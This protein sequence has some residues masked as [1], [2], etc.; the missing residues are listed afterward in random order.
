MNSKIWL[1]KDL[2][3]LRACEAMIVYCVVKW[4]TANKLFEVI[5]I[6]ERELRF[7]SRD[8]NFLARLLPNPPG[9]SVIV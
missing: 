2:R 8:G 5:T 4:F 3:M 7:V 1:L 9:A 6:H